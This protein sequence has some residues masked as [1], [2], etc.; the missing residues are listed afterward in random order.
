MKCFNLINPYCYEKVSRPF[1]VI[2]YSISV[3]V[4]DID[5]DTEEQE[6]RQSQADVFL[7]LYGSRGDTGSRH[8]VKR[9]DK[10]DRFMSNQVGSC[11]Y[12]QFVWLNVTCG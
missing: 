4:S 1:A 6:M 9:G 10:K 8:L 7:R 3:L 11:F 2:Q 5:A 12:F